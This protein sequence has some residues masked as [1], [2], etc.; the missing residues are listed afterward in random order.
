M[1]LQIIYLNYVR[2]PEP[3]GWRWI[4]TFESY[5]GPESPIGG[6]DTPGE[7]VEALLESAGVVREVLP[8]GE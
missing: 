4:A 1:I 5:D 6:G 8:E 7:A 3:L 2:K